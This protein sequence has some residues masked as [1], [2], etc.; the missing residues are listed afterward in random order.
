MAP[1]SGPNLS[2]VAGCLFASSGERYA[3]LLKGLFPSRNNLVVTIG[4]SFWTK[5]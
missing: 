2:T 4:P 5:M 1:G 3:L